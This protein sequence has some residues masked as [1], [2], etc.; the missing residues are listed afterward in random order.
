M[1][2]ESVGHSLSRGCSY[3]DGEVDVIRLHSCGIRP[4]EVETLFS[5]CNPGTMITRWH[6]DLQGSDANTKVDYDGYD[7]ER[8]LWRKDVTTRMTKIN[9]PSSCCSFDISAK[10]ILN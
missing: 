9:H 8:V 2:K 1:V 3:T 7:L 4:S 10:D 5:L 6:E